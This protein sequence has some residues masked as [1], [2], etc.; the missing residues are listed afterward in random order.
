LLDSAVFA[1]VTEMSA[2]LLCVLFDATHRHHQRVIERNLAL[3]WRFV[4]PRVLELALVFAPMRLSSFVLLML[5]E[6][7]VPG[8]ACVGSVRLRTLRLIESECVRASQ[9]VSRRKT[10]SQR[11]CKI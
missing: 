1:S 8:L 4:R 10:I 9:Y 2:G 7:L 5:F 11:S 3:Q 6:H